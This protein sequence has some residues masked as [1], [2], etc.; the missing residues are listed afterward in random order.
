MKSL[1]HSRF[2]IGNL[3]D[4]EWTDRRGR[5]HYTDHWFQRRVCRAPIPIYLPLPHGSLSRSVTYGKLNFN[6]WVWPSQIVSI[7]TIILLSHPSP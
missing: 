1:Q 6:V 7:S 4:Q 2:S 5:D 3:T